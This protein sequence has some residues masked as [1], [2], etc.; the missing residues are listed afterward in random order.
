MQ[1]GAVRCLSFDR[2]DF[3]AVQFSIY[4]DLLMTHALS[5]FIVVMTIL[6]LYAPLTLAPLL[7]LT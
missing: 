4:I 7:L 3:D 1:A 6:R 2:Y 5:F